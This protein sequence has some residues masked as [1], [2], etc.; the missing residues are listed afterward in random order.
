MRRLRRLLLLV[1]RRRCSARR[2]SPAARTRPTRARSRRPRVKGDGFTVKMPGDAQARGHHGRQTA[3]GPVPI[4]AYITEGGDE[5]FSMSV[6]NVPEGVKGDLDGAVQG[7]ATNV[8][9][10]AEG[11]REDDATR[12]S[13]RAMRGS[14]TRRTRTATR[15]RSSRA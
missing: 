8:K 12:A 14:R 11:H 5:G 2:S 6:L 1:A 10:T 3:A 13:R 15:A 9:G 7:A 4:T